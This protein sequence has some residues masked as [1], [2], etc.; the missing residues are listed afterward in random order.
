MR[1]FSK[2]AGVLTAFAMLVSVI[3]ANQ[4][5]GFHYGQ[6]PTPSNLKKLRK[7]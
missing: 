4:G 3:S 5:C 7:F 2:F 1:L 6:A